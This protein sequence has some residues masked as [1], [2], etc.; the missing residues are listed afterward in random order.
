MYFILATGLLFQQENVPKGLLD[1]WFP[2]VFKL[3]PLKKSSIS[4]SLPYV[5]CVSPTY[6][7][8]LI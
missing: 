5:I 6:L 3:Y 8:C 7:G 4:L 1:Q 2:N